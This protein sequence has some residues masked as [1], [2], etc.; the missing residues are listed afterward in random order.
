MRESHRKK[1]FCLS[2]VNKYDVRL[3]LLREHVYQF[4]LQSMIITPRC[5]QHR[6][7]ERVKAVIISKKR[8]MQESVSLPLCFRTESSQRA[9]VESGENTHFLKCF[10]RM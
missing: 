1:H 4:K 2:S 9:C 6:I 7:P 10:S 8:T 5:T 3:K